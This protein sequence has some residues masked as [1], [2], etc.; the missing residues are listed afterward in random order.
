MAL[1]HTHFYFSIQY[2][3]IKHMSTITIPKKMT[4]KE[5]LVVIPRK[6]YERMKA[7]M[8]PTVYL[9]G[10]K[11]E[12]LDK[13]VEKALRVYRKGRTRKIRSLADLT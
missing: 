13:R 2:D 5:E 11:A 4:G 8:F 1:S 3:T 9:T 10:K 7:S 12:K 6:E